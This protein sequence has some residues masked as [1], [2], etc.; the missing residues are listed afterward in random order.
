MR[1]GPEMRGGAPPWGA[2][3]T[4]RSAPTG[5]QPSDS[6]GP[7]AWVM[8]VGGRGSS[9]PS[10]AT[11]VCGFVSTCLSCYARRRIRRGFT[12]G[13]PARAHRFREVRQVVGELHLKAPAAGRDADRGVVVGRG[14]QDRTG[15][16]FL[17]WPRGRCRR[18]RSPWCAR[19][20]PGRPWRR[21]C[22]PPPWPGPSGP[23]ARDGDHGDH[24]G[25]VHVRDQGLE[26]AVR[27]TPI[28]SA[29]SSP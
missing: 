9:G 5:R 23:G 11:C 21:A 14:V 29:A 7:G 16:V 12:H 20:P 6:R 17:R 18:G 27:E 19:R 3:G 4:A 15:A 8:E 1:G 22:R 26:D 10:C 25:A 2:G 24:E 13:R 28:A